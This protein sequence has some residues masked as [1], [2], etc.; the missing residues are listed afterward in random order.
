MTIL[1][2]YTHFIL[3]IF[4][5]TVVINDWLKFFTTLQTNTTNMLLTV[6]EYIMRLSLLLKLKSI[7]EIGLSAEKSP[8]EVCV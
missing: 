3:Y 2:C 6:D 5:D 1:F 8:R 4:Y 7:A